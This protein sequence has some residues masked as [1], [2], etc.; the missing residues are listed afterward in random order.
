[1]GSGVVWDSQPRIEWDECGTKC[2]FLVARP[3]DFEIFETILFERGRPRFWREHIARMRSSAAFFG[4]PFATRAIERERL[5][6]TRGLARGN[7]YRVRLLVARDGNI[8]WE[9]SILPGTTPT[10]RGAPVK[11]LPRVVM[12]RKPVNESEPLL[13][14]KTTC[15]PWYESAMAHARAGAYYDMV[16]MNSRGQITECSM[17]NIFIEKRSMLY[18]PPI[19]CGLLPGVLRKR[20]LRGGKCRER[21]LKTRDL[22]NA[23]AVYC[24]NSVRGLVRVK[25]DLR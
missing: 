2:A 10:V 3:P 13:F 19:D 17:N 22:L 6:I 4:Y 20:L 12:A 11:D 21:I 16:F 8:R 7:R 23:D 15:R 1:M 14:H 18:T 24:G 5:R 9:S 25:P